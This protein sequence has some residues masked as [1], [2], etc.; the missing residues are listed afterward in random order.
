MAFN[1]SGTFERIY[2]WVNDKANGIKIVASRMDGEFDGI[3]TGL[4]NCIT[5]DGQ[6]TITQNI[7]FNS[8]KITG[9]ANGTDRTDVINV[10]QVQDNQFNYWGTTGGSADVYTLTP[11]PTITAYATTQ[12][13][14]AKISATNATTTPYLQISGIANPASTAVIKKLNASRAEIAVEAGDLLADG[15]YTFQR[16]SANNAWILLN[17]E[18]P[19]V[20]LVN[21]TGYNVRATT[22]TQG[23]VYLNNP[24][25]IA[26]NSGTPNTKIDFSAGNARLDDGSGQMILSSTLTKILQSSGAWTAGNDANGL[27]TSAKANSTKYYLFAITNGTINDAGYDTSPTGANIPAGYKG[28]YRGMIKTDS[29][30]NILA[31]KQNKNKFLLTAQ[32]TEYS[33]TV[34]SSYT[35]L[36]S[37]NVPLKDNIEAITNLNFNVPPTETN[38]RSIKFKDLVSS[39]EKQVIT[40][41]PVSG[42][43][44]V[45]MY[46]TSPDVAIGLN[47]SGQFQYK[48]VDTQTPTTDSS[49]AGTLE[50][51]LN[52]WIDN[53]IIL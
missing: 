12:Q 20:N 5:K 21:G 11:S 36:S 33:G 29:S 44:S 37:T 49:T 15:I 31:F 53:N 46:A 25:T 7:P 30:G 19:F 17:P 16:N 8:K 45:T 9:L 50:I 23:I 39:Q 10:G 26:N 42:G 40:I 14:T 6:T 18:K 41:R 4:S 38:G 43:V 34:G 13:F 51:R 52:G 32:I 47:S 35:N 1:G 22:T 24:I 3:A 48:S 27:F 28:S 2:N